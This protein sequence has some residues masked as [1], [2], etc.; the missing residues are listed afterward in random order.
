[1]ANTTQDTICE[2]C[3]RATALWCE[4]CH[5]FTCTHYSLWADDDQRGPNG[6]QLVHRCNW[7]QVELAEMCEAEYWRAQALIAEMRA[8]VQEVP[9]YAER[10]RSS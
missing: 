7:C 1:M 4:K 5:T 9:V 10:Y 8:A 2:H 3:T 6:E